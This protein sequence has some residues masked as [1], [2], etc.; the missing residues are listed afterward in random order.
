MHRAGAS[1]DTCLSVRLGVC[2]TPVCPSVCRTPVRP[3]VRLSVPV[4][5][6]TATASPSF[7]TARFVF[8]AF[9]NASGACTCD[10]PFSWKVKR[11][12][13][14][15]CIRLTNAENCDVCTMAAAFTPVIALPRDVNLPTVG[16]AARA[17]ACVGL[18][19]CFLACCCLYCRHFEPTRRAAASAAATSRDGR[20]SFLP[21]VYRAAPFSLRVP[22]PRTLPVGSS[23]PWRCLNIESSIS[24]APVFP[25][26]TSRSEQYFFAS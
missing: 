21:S 13:Q 19:R 12:P 8:F 6:C 26:I 14:L 18:S 4:R 3:S 25:S 15:Q 20:P 9:R 17:A 23:V 7:H 11:S 24:S 16:R 10:E 5:Q 1:P 2:R 22:V